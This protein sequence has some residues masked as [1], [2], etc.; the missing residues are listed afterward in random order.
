LNE[1]ATSNVRGAPWYLLRVGLIANRH[2]YHGR[3]YY[4][5]VT[6]PLAS[7]MSAAMPRVRLP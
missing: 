5:T 4:L 7:S 2:L 3:G 1:P 6:E